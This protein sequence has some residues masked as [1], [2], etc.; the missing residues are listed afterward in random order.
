VSPKLI[1]GAGPAPLQPAASDQPAPAP[2]FLSWDDFLSRTTPTQRRNWCRTKAKKAN[3]PRLMS[4]SPDTRITTGDV[5]FVLEKAQG[6]CAHCGSLAVEHRPSKANG[7]PLPWDHVGRRIGSLGHL[8]SRFQG[9][10]NHRSN[11]VWSCLWCNTWPSE[12]TR[13]ATDHGG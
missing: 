11:L 5:W 13:D 8:V 10:P 3:G 6:R 9:G 12:R 7:A 2:T 1:A 4:G